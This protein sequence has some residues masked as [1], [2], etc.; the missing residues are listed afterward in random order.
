M[1]FLFVIR[2]Q[3]DGT[4]FSKNQKRVGIYTS[5]LEQIYGE[6]NITNVAWNNYWSINFSMFSIGIILKLTDEEE[7]Q[8]EKELKDNNFHGEFL[9]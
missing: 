1:T 3:N 5:I 2:T 9:I 6:I 7:K 8:K 4:S